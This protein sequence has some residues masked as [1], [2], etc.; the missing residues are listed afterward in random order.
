MGYEAKKAGLAAG[1]VT[2]PLWDKLIF[3]KTRARL[4]GRVRFMISGSAP[5]SSEVMEFLRIA[6]CCPVMEGYGQTET[7]AGAFITSLADTSLGH[8]GVPFPCNEAKLVDV[9]EMNYTSNDKPFPRGEIC[10]R[11]HNCFKGY[12]KMPDKTGKFI[13][14]GVN[15]TKTF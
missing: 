5:L 8:V 1:S 14:D 6:F 4:G 15:F 7:S 3:S 12:L 10:F 11:G 2:H 13:G 9:P